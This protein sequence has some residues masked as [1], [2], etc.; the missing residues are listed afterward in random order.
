MIRFSSHAWPLFIQKPE[1]T[2]RRCPVITTEEVSRDR[3]EIQTVGR[4][5]WHIWFSR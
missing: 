5:F 2:P 4:S 3:Q 1:A